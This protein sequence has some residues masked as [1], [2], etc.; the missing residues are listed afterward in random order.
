MDQ[1]TITTTT[2][3][4]NEPWTSVI[5]GLLLPND[6][7][8]VSAKAILKQKIDDTIQ[9]HIQPE[10]KMIYDDQGLSF[11]KRLDNLERTT[12]NQQGQIASLQ[13]RDTKRQDQIASLQDRDT[14]QQDQIATLQ[15]ELTPLQN[16]MGIIRFS[17]FLKY[18]PSE[19][20]VDSYERNKLVHG[21][22]VSFDLRFLESVD[23]MFLQRHGLRHGDLETAFSKRY[24]RS[25]QYFRSRDLSE[26]MEQVVNLRCSREHLKFWKNLGD[27]PKEYDDKRNRLQ[28]ACDRTM[29][30]WFKPNDQSYSIDDANASWDHL[31][32]QYETLRKAIVAEREEMMNS[33][34]MMLLSTAIHTLFVLPALLLVSIP[35]ALSASITM[36]LAF[37]ALYLR[38]FIIYIELAGALLINFFLFPAHS[39]TTGSFLAFSEVNTPAGS[40]S[41]SRSHHPHHHHHFNPTHDA[42]SWGEKYS[43]SKEVDY[44]HSHHSYH[45]PPLT[46]SREPFFNFISGDAERDFEGVGGWRTPLQSR[47]RD[48]NSSSPPGSYSASEEGL[49]DDE[50]AWLSLNKRLELPS[51]QLSFVPPSALPPLQQQQQQK[52]ATDTSGPKRPR[53]HKRS[54]TTSPVTVQ[55]SS[56]LSGLPPFSEEEQSKNNNT[57]LQTSKSSAGLESL[58]LQPPSSKRPHS[59]LLSS[60]DY[61]PFLMTTS[62]SGD[63]WKMAHYPSFV[64]R[65]SSA[66]S[67]SQTNRSL[68]GLGLS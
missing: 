5:G 55:G 35:L 33:I 2:T 32:D 36:L 25:H 57:R 11:S 31:Y 28:G 12:G 23:E 43:A 47:K 8:Q 39:P 56:S 59:P 42:K 3:L 6:P 51:R 66:S 16:Q 9:L 60:F 50:Q 63:E 37:A 49:L 48:P 67:S 24:S 14:K 53:Y 13:D 4:Q 62:G 65:R 61:Q 34:R 64:R 1:I 10:G 29:R 22:D 40:P 54:I 52:T 21:G 30:L 45:G 58:L 7:D 41:K 38:A 44:F 17:E 68:T 18:L 27:L 19:K 26:A 15:N 46:P 20:R